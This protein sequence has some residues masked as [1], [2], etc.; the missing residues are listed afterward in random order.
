MCACARALTLASLLG[1]GMRVRACVRLCE[2][3]CTSAGVCLRACRFTYLVRHAQEPY[4]HLQPLWL[5]CFST[6]SPKWHDFRENVFERKM[7][8]L[9]FSTILFETFHIPRRIQRDIVMNVTIWSC[10][11][12]VTLSD[13][14]E[15]LI[16]STDF[17][18]S[19]E[20]KIS[21]KSVQLEPSCSLR[22]DRRTT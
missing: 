18:K 13:F 10:E 7:C 14:N 11:V 20:Y 3:G 2:C 5:R 8:V 1:V 15:T 9:I 6:L 17:L 16:S 22:I 19:L 12:P 4:C 21:S